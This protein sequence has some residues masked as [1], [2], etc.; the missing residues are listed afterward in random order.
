MLDLTTQAGAAA[1]V[2]ELDARFHDV[3]TLIDVAFSGPE[4]DWCLI[5][6]TFAETDF[7]GAWQMGKFL[8]SA[9]QRQSNSQAF[10]KE[11][12]KAVHA[13]VQ[14]NATDIALGHDYSLE[15]GEVAAL[16]GTD[17]RGIVMMA[18]KHINSDEVLEESERCYRLATGVAE[19]LTTAEAAQALEAALARLEESLEVDSFA[20]A[21]ELTLA[22][23]D[24][25]SAVAGFLWAA[26]GDPHAK[27]RWRATHAVRTMLEL[28][29]VDV[30]NAIQA[31][32]ISGVAPGFTD[33]RFPFYDMHA[34]N[35][36]LIAIDR[37]AKDD[38]EAA[39]MLLPAVRELGERH[40]DHTAIQHL[41]HLIAARSDPDGAPVG[42]DWTALLQAPVSL[43]KWERPQ[44]PKPFS[45]KAVKTEIHFHFDLEEFLLADLT[46]SF[47]ISHQAVMDALSRQILDEWHWR[48][49]HEIDHDP[50]H[51]AGVYRDGETYFYKSDYPEAEDLDF[52]LTYHAAQTV[53]GQLVRSFKPYQDPDEAQPDIVQWMQRFDLSRA[54][55]NWISDTRRPVPAQLGGLIPDHPDPQWEFEVTASDFENAIQAESGWLTVWQSAES[56]QYEAMAE[57]NIVSALVT[58]DVA[59]ALLRSLQTASDFM[60]YRLPAADDEDYTF[61]TGL[62]RLRGWIQTPYSEAGIDGR[63]LFALHLQSPLP[64]PA[65]W[66]VDLLTL[67]V[68]S[69]GQEWTG[70]T[71]TVIRTETWAEKEQGPQDPRG[72]KG[73]RVL[74]N[75]TGLD[76]LLRSTG[77]ALIVECAV[78]R[79]DP[80]NRR[81]RDGSEEGLGYFASYTKLFT[82][83]PE[84]GWRDYRGP[85]GTGQADRD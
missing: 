62:F 29:Q 39:A 15:R 54:D 79:R 76:N 77:T 69:T 44:I 7:L 21:G 53:A 57:C 16:L 32:A 31:A 22:S 61:D 6:R 24:I 47:E 27:T 9:M 51:A 37:V 84:G 36:L 73:H 68:D 13:F 18:L 60:N 48:G 23:M 38:P 85:T 83:E 1:A 58:P 80:H 11:L 81:M 63:D 74:I 14:T 70:R 75:Q 17:L 25:P 2:A 20:A 34:A 8:T 71:D 35:W 28:R 67:D 3:D 41:C 72:P 42:T 46:S 43:S 26:L 30:I 33:P 49:A 12:R 65:P 5:V 10:Q 78:R 64:T 50:R 4:T 66:V 19:L 55:R 52:Y 40:R 82:Y 56:S 59:A 45:H